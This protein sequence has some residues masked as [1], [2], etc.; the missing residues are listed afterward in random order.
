RSR[1]RWRWEELDPERG[2]E[3]GALA[4]LLATETRRQLLAVVDAV[5]AGCRRLW[6]LLL[7]GRSYRE[8]SEL[9]GVGEGALRVRVLRC[10][11]RALA[12]AADVTGSAAERRNEGRAET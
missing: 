7:A 12:L 4:D 1:S 10:R 8:M 3:S 6:E 11:R 5:P 2:E 9:L